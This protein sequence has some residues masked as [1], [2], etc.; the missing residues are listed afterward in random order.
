[1]KNNINNTQTTA[2]S[3]PPSYVILGN[4][5]VVSYAEFRKDPAGWLCND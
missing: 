4:G 5:L 1:M 3:A 2:S